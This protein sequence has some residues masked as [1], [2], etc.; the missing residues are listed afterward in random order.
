MTTI[1]QP[2]NTVRVI[3]R[4]DT[5]KDM[6]VAAV[7]DELGRFIATESFPTTRHAYRRLLGW[8]QS[9]GEVIS[10]GVEGCGSWWPV[11]WR[12]CWSS[13]RRGRRSTRF[14]VDRS[15]CASATAATWCICNGAPRRPRRSIDP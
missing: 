15:R 7:I 14:S 10:V 5:H 4:V 1:A 11:R 13:S 12:W 2:D 3:G 6:H 9:H 8:L